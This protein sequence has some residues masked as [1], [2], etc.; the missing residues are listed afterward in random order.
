M[1]FGSGIAKKIPKARPVIIKA[2]P[3]SGCNKTRPAAIPHNTKGAIYL[4]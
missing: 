1:F 4:K 3:R 2:V